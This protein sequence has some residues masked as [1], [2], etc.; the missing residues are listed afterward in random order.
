MGS[1]MC[2]RDRYMITCGNPQ[3]DNIA[4]ATIYLIASNICFVLDPFTHRFRSCLAGVPGVYDR[5]V[6][7]QQNGRGIAH[8]VELLKTQQEGANPSYLQNGVDDLANETLAILRAEEERLPT[9]TIKHD[10]V[11]L[12]RRKLPAC[13]A[14]DLF[15]MF[16]SQSI[17][18]CLRSH[19]VS[20]QGL[21]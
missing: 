6:S 4:D 19:L 10:P 20:L 2:I 13:L 3:A 12:F 15:Y 8:R 16:V 7:L 21:R 5:I 14:L 11:L 9:Q 1:E 18:P 17:R